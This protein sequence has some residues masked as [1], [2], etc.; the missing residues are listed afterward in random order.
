MDYIK[1]FQKFI[2]SSVVNFLAIKN[3]EDRLIKA[4]YKRVFIEES[5]DISL[6]DKIYFKRNDLSIIAFNI[7]S[8]VNETNYPFNIIASHVDSPCYKVKPHLSSDGSYNVKIFVKDA[9]GN[10]SV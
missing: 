3:A 6:G 1:D 7:G 8:L 9:T 5:G 10:W 4:G 2:D